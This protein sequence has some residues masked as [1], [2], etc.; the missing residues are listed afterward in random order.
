MLLVKQYLFANAKTRKNIEGGYS[1][2]KRSFLQAGRQLPHLPPTG[3]TA[4]LLNGGSLENAQAIATHDGVA[5]ASVPTFIAWRKDLEKRE[6]APASI[7]RKL[8]ALS[9]LFDYLCNALKLRPRVS[10]PSQITPAEN[11]N[12]IAI[13]TVMAFVSA[14]PRSCKLPI[15]IGMIE[16]TAA[17]A[18]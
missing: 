14:T 4:S 13:A 7:R 1:L 6:L 9:A 18:W 5:A 17:A 10:G 8:S 11:I 3:I 16:A 15:R 2:L 12:V